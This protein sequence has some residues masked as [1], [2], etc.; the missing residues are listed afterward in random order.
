MADITPISQQIHSVASAI[1]QECARVRRMMA[2]AAE[3][4]KL[5]KPDT[6]L[7]RQTYEPFPLEDDP[8][9]RDDIHDLLKSELRP[10]K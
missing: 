8:I 7:G 3:V 9:L 5:P 10:P 4:L 1:D 6:F 2:L